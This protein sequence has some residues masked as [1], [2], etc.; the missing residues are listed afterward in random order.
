M[1]IFRLIL[2]VLLLIAVNGLL[3]WLSNLPQDAGPDVPDGKI[4]SVSFAPFREGQSPLSKVFP[5]TDEIEK[6]IRL[7]SNETHSIRTYA[8]LGGL[9]DVPAIARKYG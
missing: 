5:S 2:F 4:S 6:D 8:S 1:K 7:L 9:R 3:A